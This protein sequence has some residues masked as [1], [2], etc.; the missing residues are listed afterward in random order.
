MQIK[1]KNWSVNC[2]LFSVSVIKFC[3]SFNKSLKVWKT[4]RHHTKPSKMIDCD[5][6]TISYIN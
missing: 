1:K 6:R 2:R 5:D 4:T 3:F